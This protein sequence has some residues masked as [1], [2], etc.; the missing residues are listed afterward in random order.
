MLQEG[1]ERV[2]Q[3]P[4]KTLQLAYTDIE[5]EKTFIFYF[6]LLEEKDKEK[7]DSVFLLVQDSTAV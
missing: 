1:S 6:R 3:S 2:K 7:E 5:K 4:S